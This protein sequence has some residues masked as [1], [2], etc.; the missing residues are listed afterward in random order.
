MDSEI[1]KIMAIFTV[2]SLIVSVLLYLAGRSWRGCRQDKKKAEVM[3]T[4]PTAS[5]LAKDWKVIERANPRGKYR[6]YAPEITYSYYIDGKGY[7]IKV[8]DKKFY[9]SSYAEDSQESQST[10][11]RDAAALGRSIVEGGKSIQIY[12]N[13]NDPSESAAEIGEFSCVPIF[14]VVAILSVVLLISASIALFILGS[15]VVMHFRR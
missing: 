6:H 9:F 3:H 2:I 12:Y 1:I 8:A 10:A 13:P 4:W 14:V 11:K 7:I 5:A 15:I